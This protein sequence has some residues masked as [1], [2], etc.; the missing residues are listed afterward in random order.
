MKETDAQHALSDRRQVLRRP[1][2]AGPS[3]RLRS[4]PVSP[5]TV[6]H[7]ALAGAFFVLALLHFATWAAVRSQRVQLWLA[8]SFLGFAVLSMAT[9]LTHP[10]AS[11]LTSDTRPWILL[12]VLPSIPLPYTLLR[13][14][15]SLLDV[16]LT[17][18]RRALLAVALV[19]G[20]VRVLDVAWSLLRVPE[21][22]MNAEAISHA[23]AGLSLPLFWL[24]ATCVAGTWA[25]EAVRLLN[26]RGAMAVAVLAASFVAL[27]LLGRELAI[28]VGW[29]SGRPLFVLVG[30]PFLLLAS[31]SLAILTARSLRGADL[32]TG[33]HR[34]RRLTQLGKG[35]MGEV[36][37]A[38][39]TG[40]AGFHRLVV[41]KRML[42]NE[43]DD[44]AVQVQRFIGEA[45]TSARLHH[46]NIVSV[47]DLGQ[48]DGAWFIVMEYL[49]GVNVLQLVRRVE[50]GGSLPLEVII[51]ICQQALRGLAYAHEQGV[52][53]RD[54]SADNL[55]V[56]F[57]GV[58]KVVDFG[59]A[60]R[61]GEAQESVPAVATS[62]A[63][64]ADSRLTQVGLVI[65]KAPYMPPERREGG[66]ATA[67]GDLFALGCSLYEMLFGELPAVSA[68]GFQVPRLDRPEA[69]SV[70]QR[71]R[72][73]LAVALH[74]QLE[75]RFPDARAFQRAL[76]PLRH[77]L[78][79]VE[80]EQWLRENFAAR[81]ERERALLE[82]SDPMPADVEALNTRSLTPSPNAAAEPTQLMKPDA[83]APAAE[84]KTR[85]VPRSP[86]DPR[87]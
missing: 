22:G 33:I 52:I 49:S 26:R 15:W 54:I 58:V 59:I 80:L 6:L 39:R 41:L 68:S 71:L 7:L 56:S 44:P 77:D 34:Y 9:G 64:P 40:R 30:L 25:F 5:Y 43:A 35:G 76:E 29:L 24:L 60:H 72:A 87:P 73:I 45:R 16:P 20:A 8:S 66:E 46:P 19:L 67:S 63:V 36:W 17:R 18:W 74:P 57:D 53:H 55:F 11:A 70:A 21:P 42:A 4:A 13:T 83:P 28:D 47:Y 32:G 31:T 85:L 69:P 82:L 65:G 50:K 3:G 23:A 51:E 86:E 61:S 27:L 84:Q 75:R 81:W 38:V 37:L 79:P 2:H 1:L 48:I 10:E 62:G 14:A 78:P 12:G